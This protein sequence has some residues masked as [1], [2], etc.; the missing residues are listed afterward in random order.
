MVAARWCNLLA[1]RTLGMQRKNQ[2]SKGR[3]S[4]K[5]RP[6]LF[7]FLLVLDPTTCFERLQT[8]YIA[9]THW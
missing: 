3:T 2:E 9:K 7:V 5:K 1:E 4:N 6:Y 8:E